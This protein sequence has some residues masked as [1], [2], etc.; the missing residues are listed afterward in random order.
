MHLIMANFHLGQEKRNRN[1]CSCSGQILFPIASIRRYGSLINI[2]PS[3]CLPSISHPKHVLVIL[4][5][6]GESYLIFA[7][8]LTQS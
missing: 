6:L 3:A 8:L 7:Y 5:Y 2:N 1:N 4:I